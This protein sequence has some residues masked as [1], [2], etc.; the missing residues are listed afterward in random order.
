MLRDEKEMLNDI[1]DL[2][3]DICTPE[4]LWPMLE[5]LSEV[6]PDPKFSTRQAEIAVKLADRIEMQ[7]HDATPEGRAIIE[8][9][10]D[11]PMRR[12]WAF[13]ADGSR[14]RVSIPRD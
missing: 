7:R 10:A 12:G 5:K 1:A 9:R 8:G 4:M 2:L 6:E 3:A 13:A 14:R 11:K